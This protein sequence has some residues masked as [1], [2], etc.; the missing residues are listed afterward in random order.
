MAPLNEQQ[1]EQ[2]RDERRELILSAALR[3]FSRRGVVGT[4]MSMIA[5]EAGIS[6]G[7]LYHYFKSKDE[8]L[9]T[10]VRQ[11]MDGAQEAMESLRL[12]P[13]SA[14]EKIRGY[15]REI[16]DE[17]GWPYFQLLHHVRTSEGVPEEVKGLI[18]RYSMDA[19]IA[20]LT[21]LFVEAQADGDMIAGD[22]AY[23]IACFLTV[24]AGLVTIVAQDAGY[25]IPE[26]DMLI[27]MFEVR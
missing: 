25:R 22:P 7:L 12:L 21:P 24:F 27:R 5:A 2:I 9:L 15:A 19:Y 26:P 1:L 11:A 6:H 10:L 17:E 20:Q 23:L 4:K 3:V 8:L 14:F 16:L 13:G 18:A